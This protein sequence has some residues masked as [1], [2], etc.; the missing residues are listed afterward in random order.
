M[1]LSKAVFSLHNEGVAAP[2]C[3]PLTLQP[4]QSGGRGSNPA[5]TFECRDK[6]LRTRLAL[7]LVLKTATSP[8]P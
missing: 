7:R 1:I 8:S 3:D 4:E 5:S 2:C 6:G